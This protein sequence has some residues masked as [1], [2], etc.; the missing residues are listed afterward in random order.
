M[1]REDLERDAKLVSGYDPNNKVKDMLNSTST[2]LTNYASSSQYQQTVDG[3]KNI[4]TSYV[5]AVSEGMGENTSSITDYVT[6]MA[7]SMVDA[8][9]GQYTLFKEAGTNMV[10]GI[11]NGIDEN[12]HNAVNEVVA[13]AESMNQAFRDTLDINSPSK[14]YASYGMYMIKG[15]VNGLRD[16][17]HLSDRAAADLGNSAI[18]NLKNSIKQITEMAESDID[19]QPTIRPVLDLSDIHKGTAQLNSMFSRAQAMR[20]NA[21]MNN[22]KVNEIQNG[23]KDTPSAGN[24]YNYTQNN[25]SPKAL[26][27]AEI[28]RQTKNQFA[29]MKGA[30]T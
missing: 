13:L 18:E 3:F 6:S 7:K 4:G 1:T 25:Y 27:R 9:N 20:I 24:T 19:T 12:A 26:S 5:D 2:A 30:T 16:N 23:V 14:V 29:A 21:D 28:Y 8:L 11:I 17:A 15:L 22:Q 10:I